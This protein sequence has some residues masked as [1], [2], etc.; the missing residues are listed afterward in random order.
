MAQK[1]DSELIT[2]INTAIPDNTTGEVDPADVRERIL[3][4]VDSLVNNED[5][6]QG[7][8]DYL[9]TNL[10]ATA[11][12]GINFDDLTNTITISADAGVV[13]VLGLDSVD[14]SNSVIQKK[15]LNV[16]SILTF[17]NGV[18]GVTHKLILTAIGAARTV[19][20]PAT[21]HP[22]PGGTKDIVISQDTTRVLKAE[23]DG[24][25]YYWEIG[26]ELSDS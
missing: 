16:D 25:D 4:M 5:L 26:S 9:K 11:G 7:V 12:L 15:A 14:W 20:L 1:P 23:Y 2:D 13:Y 17:S 18:V 19:T 8:Y 22:V 10:V 24:T 3:D 21:N 6:P